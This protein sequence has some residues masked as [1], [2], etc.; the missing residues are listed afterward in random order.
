MKERASSLKNGDKGGMWVT[1]K[2]D[3][4]LKPKYIKYPVRNKKSYRLR[5]AVK[6]SPRQDMAIA[7]R[8]S[9]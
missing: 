4:H 3:K 2:G 1:G 8:N 9:L 6:V 7:L 5:S